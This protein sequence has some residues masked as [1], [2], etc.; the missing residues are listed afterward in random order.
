MRKVA[1]FP[2]SLLLVFCLVSLASAQTLDW[3]GV[4]GGLIVTSSGRSGMELTL[5]R[6]GAT[7]NS[8]LRLH[9]DGRELKPAVKDLVMKGDYVSFTTDVL[10]NVAKCSGSFEGDTLTGTLDIFSGDTRVNGGKFVLMRG[11]EMVIP[12]APTGQIADPDFNTTVAKPAYAKVGPKV[13]FDEAHNNFHTAGGRYKPFADLISS[14]G[15]LIVHNSEKFSPEVLK[16]FSVLVIS[17]ALGSEDMGAEGADSPAF[18]EAESDAVRD[19]VKAGGSLLLIADHAPMGSAN[20]I[21]AS[22]F[23]VDMSKR[24]TIDSEN[25]E[26]E[27]SNQGFIVYTR[28]SGRLADHPITNGRNETERVN[29]IIA[30]TGQSLK[31][32]ANSKSI[33]SLAATAQDVMRGQPPLSAAG[34]SQGIAMT[35]GKGRVVVLGEAGMLT[36]Q[37][38][39]PNKVPFGMNRPGIDNR[40][41]ALNIMHWLTGLL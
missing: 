31:G 29:K 26:K 28:E 14:D 20:Q 24:F 2:A 10:G 5:T 18:T 33:M 4:W 8:A 41:F 15:H 11:A 30:F 37:V 34:R 1:V 6:D 17:N 32:P 27:S 21:L 9:I 19:W 40:Q 23:E 38:T 39:G 12:V 13:L 7:W 22:R 3:K 35:V 16:G 36:A 25:F